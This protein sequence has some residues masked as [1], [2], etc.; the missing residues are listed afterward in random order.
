MFKRLRRVRL[1]SVVRN[2]IEE[3]SLRVQ[4]LIYP[5]F[6]THGE[7]VK[8]AVASLP[9]VYQ[10]SID[11]A[12]KEC[13]KLSQLGI[14]AIMLF[15]IP[16][17]KDSIGSEAL[18]EQGIIAQALCAIKEKFPHLLLCVDLCFCE[19]TDHGH[20]GILNPKLQ[21]VDNDLTLEI[22]NQQA[23]VLAK[24]GADLIAPSGMMDGMILSLRQALDDAGFLHI[25]LMS[26]STK[27]ASGYYGP[28]RDVAQSTPSFGDRK[29]YQQNPANR[30][31]AILESLEDEAQGAD[32]L[33][34]KPALAYL[35]IVRDIRERSLLPLAVYNVSGEYAMLKFAQKAGLIDYERV[36]IET[37]LCFKRA[38]ADIIITYHAKEIAKLLNGI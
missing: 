24:A 31:E 17:L 11:N 16:S 3:N 5:L 33:M 28:F 13:A 20:C 29:S 32:I 12:L 22:L 30:R 15:G 2:L 23:L 21:S 19:Y 34:V 37:M 25:P 1:N 4:D 9:D 35:D 18:S 38:G 6:I 36:L 27:F 10:L 7:N 8:N 14:N 26:Y